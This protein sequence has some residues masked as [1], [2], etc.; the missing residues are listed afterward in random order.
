M[1]EHLLATKNLAAIPF[2]NYCGL[3]SGSAQGYR[4]ADLWLSAEVSQNGYLFGRV[5]SLEA[6]ALSI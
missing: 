5:T 2:D 1:Q 3:N 6:F 4:K